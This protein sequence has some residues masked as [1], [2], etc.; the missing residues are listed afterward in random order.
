MPAFVHEQGRDD[1]NN[2]LKPGTIM[3]IAGGAV[4]AVSTFLTWFDVGDGFNGW[5][6]DFFGFQGIFVFLIGAA[7]AVAVAL[8]SFAGTQLPAR[9]LGFTLNQLFMA[10]GLAAFLITFGQQF[11]DERGFGVI[12][13]WI[14]SAVVIAGAFMEG[15]GDSAAPS[16]RPPTTF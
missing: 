16:N 5:E 11:G 12:L 14:A 9:V 6:T 3:L 8:K 13:G 4:L 10:L 2:Q 7:V 1:V 15:Q